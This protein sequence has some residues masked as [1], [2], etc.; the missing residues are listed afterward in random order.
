M[1]KDLITID[2]CGDLCNDNKYF[3]EDYKDLTQIYIFI[4]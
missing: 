3:K 2:T 4:N 1:N